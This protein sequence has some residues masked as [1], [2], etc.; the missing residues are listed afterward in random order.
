MTVSGEKPSWAQV[1]CGLP[2]RVNTNKQYPVGDTEKPGGFSKAIFVIAFEAT[3]NLLVPHGFARNICN[4]ML[5][6]RGTALHKC[7]S[8]HI[9]SPST[10]YRDDVAVAASFG[11]FDPLSLQHRAPASLASSLSDAALQ[12]SAVWQKISCAEHQPGSTGCPEAHQ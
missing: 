3:I 6:I 4:D 5:G 8:S 10:T 11:M 7:T 1:L 9:T 12:L 2:A